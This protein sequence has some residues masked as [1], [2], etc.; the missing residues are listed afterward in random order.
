MLKYESTG[1][2]GELDVGESK[3]QGQS[4]KDRVQSWG[5]SEEFRVE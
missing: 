2:C 4:A 3:Y 5:M 1:E